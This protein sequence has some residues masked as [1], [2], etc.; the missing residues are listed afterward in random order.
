MFFTKTQQRRDIDNM[1]KLFFDACTG[2]VWGDDSQVHELIC[3]VVRSDENPRTEVAIYR[4]PWMDKLN[5]AG[6]KEEL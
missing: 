1:T 6:K 2:I 5:R 4:L 3:R